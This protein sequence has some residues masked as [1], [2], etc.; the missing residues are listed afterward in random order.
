MKSLDLHHRD[1]E[2][3]KL[4]LETLI[5][6]RWLAI[7]GQFSAV[8]FVAYGLKFQFYITLCL[9][10]IALSVWLN[11]FLSLRYRANFRVSQIAA[12]SLLAFDILQLTALLY[13]TGG[14][15]NPFSLLLIV[16]VVVSAT[17]LS[18]RQTL[19]LG[20]LAVISLSMLAVFHQPLPWYSDQ[21]LVI[22]LLFVAGTWI[23]I[24]AGM[25]F[26]AIYAYR[27]A[28]ENR[29]QSN[30]LLATEVILQREQYLSSLDG[31]AA[32]AAHE[33]G[34]PLS[35]IALV[36][37]EMSRE[38]PEDSPLAE[39]ALLLRSQA[40]RCRDILQKLTSLSDQGE[41]H[42][43]YLSFASLIDE[44]IEPHRNF[45]IE[46]EARFENRIK[47]PFKYPVFVRNPAIM[48]GLG[49]LVE[50]AVDFAGSRVDIDAWWSEEQVTI[51][52]TDDGPGYPKELLGRIGEP[53]LSTRNRNKEKSGG[54]LGLGLFIAKTLLERSGATLEFTKG[55]HPD[56]PGARV[57]IA[58]PRKLLDGQI[59]AFIEREKKEQA[60]GILKKKPA[61][62]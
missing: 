18:Q 51:V 2:T 60:V 40:A 25:G 9:A 45:G 22:P 33:L 29:L 56:F 15:R 55:D 30:A 20:A 24:V 6:I 16:P 42:L 41:F 38:L 43:G 23:A 4:R 46:I 50:N 13:L 39:D 47:T 5:R 59:Q 8:M 17:T 14:L 28:N 44:V 21:E 35:T 7:F 53:Y 10:V 49:N 27:L 1:N 52:I 54:G 58:W 37:T 19:L 31:L 12:L 48:Y 57:I 3:L 62:F 61:T 34:T 26:T 11:I 32:A 36:A